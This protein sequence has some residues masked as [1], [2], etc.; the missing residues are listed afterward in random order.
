MSI[1]RSRKR[2]LFVLCL[3]VVLL[4]T[5]LQLTEVL[6]Q[7]KHNQ[8][9]NAGLPV[10]IHVV[11]NQ[12]RNQNFAREGGLDLKVNSFVL[13]ISRLSRLQSKLVLLKR[14]T[15][16]GLSP[17]LWAIFVIFGKIVVLTPFGSHFARF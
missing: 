6:S 2:I 17:D 16:G 13:K 4:L 15:D 12:V 3:L 7:T 10:R 11:C 1:K 9:R 14:R 5:S 8:R